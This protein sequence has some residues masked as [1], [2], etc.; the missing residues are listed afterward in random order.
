MQMGNEV[1]IKNFFNVILVLQVPGK[2]CTL[3]GL[4]M[5]LPMLLLSYNPF[6]FIRLI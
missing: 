6:E 1:D 3:L 5:L 4:T 2:Q